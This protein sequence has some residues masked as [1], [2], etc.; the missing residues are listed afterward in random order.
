M[1]S[2]DAGSRPLYELVADGLVDCGVSAF[3]GLMGSGN[4]GLST[5]MC[6]VGGARFVAARH[7]SAAVSMAIGYALA[8]GEVGVAT[9]H[10]GPGLTNTM[11]AL[12]EAAKGRVPLLLVA[13][14][15]ASDSEFALQDIDQARVAE[16]AGAL[17]YRIRSPER[18]VEDLR[19]A[20]A[21]AKT[22]RRPVVASLPIDWQERLLP[23]TPAPRAAVV[24]RGVPPRPARESLRRIV[25]LLEPARRPLILGGWGAYLSGAGPALI[26]LADRIKAPL[27]TTLQGD[28]LFDEAR[29]RCLGVVGGFGTPEAL[30]KVAEADLILAFGASLNTWTT[31]NES[32]FAPGATIVQVDLEPAAIGR[33]MGVDFGL[34]ADARAVAEDLTAELERSGFEG[35]SE[36]DLDSLPG[37]KDWRYAATQAEGVVDPR[38]VVEEL[39]RMLPERRA[40]AVDSGGFMGWGPMHMRVPDPTALIYAQSFGAVGLG[41]GTAVGAAVGRPD[42]LTVA[43]IGDGGLMMSMG[44]LTAIVEHEIPILVVVMNDRG[45]GAEIF[46]FAEQGIPTG[47]A[48]FR[49]VAFAE[50]AG[51]LGGRGITVR[52]VDDLAAA[53]EWI[54][55]P[56]GL[57]LLDC[58]IDRDVVAPWITS[59]WEPGR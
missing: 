33:R 8:R 59:V 37:Y 5:R 20:F 23:E 26:A 34:H 19:K 32:A 58:K 38:L 13:G 48:E 2:R 45:Y 30:A 42:R 1:T 47:L 46:H 56:A 39:D 22:Q 44:E 14:D 9:V 17:A 55:S 31:K 49:D 43:L 35:R 4:M 21:V 50:V 52:S 36:W 53:R 3:F 10:E 29:S 6:E 51:S 24:E 18:A 7:E 15:T 27:A 40:L 28:G 57:M 25:E 11:T 41:L 12:A 54:D 16:A